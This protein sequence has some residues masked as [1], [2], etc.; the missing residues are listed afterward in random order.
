MVRNPELTFFL[1]AFMA[2][3]PAAMNF[4]SRQA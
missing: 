2:F 4:E 1:S 3:N